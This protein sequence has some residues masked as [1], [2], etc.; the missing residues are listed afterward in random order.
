[1]RAVTFVHFIHYR[2]PIPGAVPEPEDVS[3]QSML[4]ERAHEHYDHGDATAYF[5]CRN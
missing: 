4:S 5:S 2:I 3:T 1:M